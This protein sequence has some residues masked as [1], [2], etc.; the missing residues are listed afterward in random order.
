MDIFA[1]NYGGLVMCQGMVAVLD[2]QDVDSGTCV[3]LGIAF[4]LHM[5][6]IGYST[7]LRRT[8]YCNAMPYTICARSC[9]ICRTELGLRE[10]LDYLVDYI[11]LIHNRT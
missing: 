1:A 4:A 7:D 6:V 11:N 10:A 9:G 8:L 2:G 5:P 3:A